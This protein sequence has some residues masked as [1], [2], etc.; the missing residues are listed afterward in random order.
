MDNIRT[1]NA[2]F[3]DIESCCVWPTVRWQSRATDA[4]AEAANNIGYFSVA[5][6]PLPK[7][8]VWAG[9]NSKISLSCS[10]LC[11][12][13]LRIQNKNNY[14]G[15]HAFWVI[16]K[17]RSGRFCSFFSVSPCW[18]RNKTQQQPK[19]RFCECNKPNC[20][21]VNMRCSVCVSAVHLRK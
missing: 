21:G 18:N 7:A 10:R 9:L 14:R 8:D 1:Q 16:F 5:V 13:S 17:R 12:C 20:S 3:L 11:F 4:S 15:E 19:N 2:L 6:S